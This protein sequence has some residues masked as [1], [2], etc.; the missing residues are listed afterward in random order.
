M[1]RKKQKREGLIA[2]MPGAIRIEMA[3]EIIRERTTRQ[4][5]KFLIRRPGR[6]QPKWVLAH[7]IVEIQRL[8]RP[9]GQP[10]TPKPLTR[11]ELREYNMLF[12]LWTKDGGPGAELLT[13]EQISRFAELSERM[14]FSQ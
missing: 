7:D 10:E 3:V 1:K 5:R 13:P 14:P 6:K 2:F 4:G 11:S 12:K 9:P 8:P